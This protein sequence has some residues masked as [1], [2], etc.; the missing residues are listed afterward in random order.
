MSNSRSHP[1]HDKRL[2]ERVIIIAIAALIILCSLYMYQQL[3]KDVKTLQWELTAQHFLTGA[4]VYKASLLM[5]LPAQSDAAAPYHSNKNVFVS[6]AGWPLSVGRFLR[7]GMTPTRVECRWLWE[8]FLRK[9]DVNSSAFSNEVI[10]HVSANTCRYMN[11]ISDHYFDYNIQT[12][13]IQLGNDASS[14][15]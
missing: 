13:S 15:K 7:E 6:P 2:L 11:D 10:I 12:G 5:D 9:S 4:A 1:G 3:A 8:Q 14:I